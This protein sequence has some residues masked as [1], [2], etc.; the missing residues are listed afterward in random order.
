M[1]TILVSGKIIWIPGVG[2]LADFL[3]F[4]I[5]HTESDFPVVHY[6]SNGNWN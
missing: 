6:A 1:V 5:P 3:D 2:A 4:F